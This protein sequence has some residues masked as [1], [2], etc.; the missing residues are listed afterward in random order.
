MNV[1]RYADLPANLVALTATARGMV[2]HTM[3]RAAQQAFGELAPAIQNAGLWP[4]ASSWL[5]I[6]PDDPQGPDD[7][8]CRYVAGVLFGHAL[9]SGQGQCE[10]PEIALSGTLAWQALSLGRCAVFTHIGPYTALHKVW[11]GIYRDWL[12]ASGHRLRDT[13]PLEL[14]LNGADQTPAEKL[15]TE[16]WIP[17]E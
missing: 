3:S 2:K 16:I 15:H 1:T 8:D 17:V 14:M 5:A 13:L 4:R 10:Q 6:C 12:P 11:S 9:A 7:P